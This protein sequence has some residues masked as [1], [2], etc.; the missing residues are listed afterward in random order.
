MAL[1]RGLVSS[2]L[3]LHV[4]LRFLMIHSLLHARLLSRM[5]GH[6]QVLEHQVVTSLTADQLLLHFTFLH[7]WIIVPPLIISRWF[8]HRGN[9]PSS[10][11]ELGASSELAYLVHS[12]TVSDRWMRRRT[13]AAELL[14]FQR[15]TMAWGLLDFVEISYIVN[16]WRFKLGGSVSLRVV[17][18]P[19]WALLLHSFDVIM[20]AILLHT[21]GGHYLFFSSL[22]QG[23]VLEPA[24]ENWIFIRTHF[25]LMSRN[26]W[27]IQVV[28]ELLRH[29]RKHLLLVFDFRIGRA[30]AS[31]VLFQVSILI[32]LEDLWN[33][34]VFEE[35]VVQ[36]YLRALI[37][38]NIIEGA[39]GSSVGGK[40][41]S[42][43]MSFIFRYLNL[44]AVVSH[45]STCSIDYFRWVEASCSSWGSNISSST[46][47]D[48]ELELLAANKLGGDLL[49]KVN[50]GWLRLVI[51]SMVV[52]D[53]WRDLNRLID[54]V[55]TFINEALV[56]CSFILLDQ[57]HDTLIRL[58]LVIIHEHFC[59][60]GH[61]LMLG[62]CLS[63]VVLGVINLIISITKPHRVV[64]K[65]I[66]V[67]TWAPSHLIVFRA[68]LR[69]VWTL[70]ATVQTVDHIQD[71]LRLIIDKLSLL[72]LGILLWLF[73][74]STLLLR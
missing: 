17:I 62:A 68:L 3:K 30:M 55:Q 45:G 21:K 7:R 27:I 35:G 36:I 69:W 41:C 57:L 29:R 66:R 59:L 24:F 15:S 43:L 22:V 20:Q 58:E 6:Y 2:L 23:V 12:M 64:S 28:Q 1:L 65:T 33:H 37:L 19:P 18:I 14:A 48:V 44:W 32:A 47:I 39:A 38:N 26:L 11:S 46:T 54:R 40:G 52:L 73:V 16:V 60:F 31:M 9:A 50:A 61:I 4:A 53:D 49:L 63:I 5:P 42:F 25:R 13:A 70:N 71:P 8:F 10:I 72:L 51:R 74:D 67:T 56:P 34:L